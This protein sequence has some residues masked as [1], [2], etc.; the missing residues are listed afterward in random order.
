MA[1]GRRLDRVVVVGGGLAASRSCAALRRQGYEGEVVLIGAE[2][3]MPYDRPP[4]S[5]GMLHGTC[6]ETTLP[7]DLPGLGVQIRLGDA[8][9]GLRPDERAV[10]TVSG[11]VSYDGLVIA[12]GARPVKLPGE[13]EQLIL[14]TIEDARLLRD[15][16][17]PGARIVV[18]GASWIG[19]EVATAAMAAGCRV[20]CLEVWPAPAAQ[21]LGAKVAERLLPWWEGVDLRCG[22]AVARVEGG[23]VLLKDGTLVPADTVVT[24]IGV[25]PETAWLEES[26]LQL[27]CGVVVDERLRAASGIVAVGDV[28]AR[29]S[30]R[31]NRRLRITHWD[32]A[33]AGSAVAVASLLAQGDDGPVF[34]PVPYFWSDQFGHKL[35]YLGQLGPDDVPEFH[36]PADG[37]GWSVTWF[38]A[39]RRLTGVLAVDRPRDIAQARRLFAADSPTVMPGGGLG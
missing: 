11:E 39:E 13:G 9:T 34:D 12:T 31:W 20:T 10:T 30:R 2:P 17:V 3:H 6:T 18:I 35:Q 22:T 21:V 4:L 14:R 25:R 8:A 16:L 28:A 7:V 33:S 24:G 23:G 19:A 36:H 32:D 29:W 5:K 38:D 26:G 15:R 1:D 37:R 27:D